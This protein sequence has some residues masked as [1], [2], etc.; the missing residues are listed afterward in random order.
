MSLDMKRIFA[1]VLVSALLAGCVCQEN[2]EGQYK[3]VFKASV[4]SEQTRLGASVDE[5]AEAVRFFWT[6]SDTVAVNTSEGF[7]PFV[8]KGEGGSPKGEF[9][10][11]YSGTL[12][13]IAVYPSSSAVTFDG[14][15]LNVALPSQYTYSKGETHALLHAPIK[16]DA[17]DFRHLA[18]LL[19]VDVAGAPEGATLVVTAPERK[20]SGTFAVDLTS[21]VP[22]LEAEAAQTD[23]QCSVRIA[24][25]QAESSAEVY[26]PM[27]VGEYPSL[28]A[29]VLDKDGTLIE[30]SLRNSTGQKTFVRAC[31]KQMPKIEM[32]LPS[33]QL[34]QRAYNMEK[35]RLT[36]GNIP[37][38][39]KVVIDFGDGTPEV[40]AVGSS[41]IVHQFEN[42]SG[43][44][45][46]FTVTLT[47]GGQIV[48]KDIYVYS[49]MALTEVA[50]RFKD[51]TC[52]DVWVMAHRGNTSDKSIP[53]NSI[54][55]V[56]ASIAAGVQVVEIDTRLTSDGEIVICHDESISRTTN[57]SGNISNLTLAQI[58]SYNLKDRNGKVTSEVM[59]T[60]EEYLEAARGKIYVNLDYSPRT[61]STA[62][63]MAVVERLGMYEQVLFYCNS[64]T[65][66]KEVGAIN[67]NAHAYAWFTNHA[68]LKQLPGEHFMQCSYTAG[69]PTDVSAS[70]NNGMICTVNMLNG[71]SDSYIQMDKLDQLFEYYPTVR[72]IQTDVSDKLV[73]VLK[74][75]PYDEQEPGVYFVSPQGA[76]SKAGDSWDNAMDMDQ[77]R[78]MVSSSSGA[79]TYSQSAMLDNSTFHFM[80]GTYCVPSPKY[81]ICRVEFQTYGED[82]SM[83]IL[84]GYD[85][86]STGTDLSKRNPAVNLTEFTGDLNANGKADA[87]DA[88]IFCLD[89]F[90]SLKI[91]GVTFAHSY[92]RS[93]WD[94]KAF[95]LNS[96]T[97]G[98]RACVDLIDCR[99]HDIYGYKD[100]E[101]KYHG[102]AAVWVGKNGQA[103]LH[104]CEMYDCHSHSRGGAIRVAES[105]G[106]VFLNE[107]LLRDNVIKDRFGSA[108][109][110]TSGS[111]LANNCTFAHN[112]GSHAVLNGGGNW[113]LVNSTVVA[114]YVSSLSDSNMVW[115]SESG[116][117]RT[118]AMVN[119]IL[120]FDGYTSVY[121][122]GSSYSMT[123]LGYN[124]TGTNNKYFTPSVKD[125]TG[126]AASGLGLTW[127]EDGYYQWNG[128]VPGFTKATLADVENAVKTGCNRSV[129]PYSNIGQGFYDWL[130]DIGGGRNPLA[131]DQA[132]NTRNPDAIWPGSYERQK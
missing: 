81:G 5:D 15:V 101:T 29:C 33:L 98:A 112:V 22:C 109:H 108:V 123:S 32:K 45:K 124:L 43:T 84:G 76:G 88:G 96:S 90:A 30:G 80:E 97:S 44:D 31:V 47:T 104:G 99:F 10:G 128:D 118:A 130:Q 61:A 39:Q 67:P 125:M 120:L 105:S 95:I 68:A 94:Q 87:E 7:V 28:S 1:A 89:A 127:C 16:G 60:L 72:L 27:P 91:D 56:E 50:K 59:P 57:G 69:S 37:V 126:C 58:R 40:T 49:L 103:R 3:A 71:V 38:G 121:I 119:S 64:A 86:F 20:I 111:F 17:L 85:S 13:D 46:T 78:T 14:S 54:P 113:L 129:G 35:V 42:N 107:C 102:G 110:V 93:R 73:D 52:T 4:E 117:D 48:R 115:R 34:K 116:S 77:W 132:G 19:K 24:F 70:L 23:G 12:G 11:Y 8:L 122:N 62:Q 92:G 79:K 51:Q 41:S 66:V 100:A 65:K 75:Y 131:F 21:D 53:E 26:V 114:D 36:Y 74:G 25:P 2:L 55:A 106:I 6:K 63:V 9:E 83:T 18:A 82:C